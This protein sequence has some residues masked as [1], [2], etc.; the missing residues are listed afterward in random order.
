MDLEITTLDLISEENF[1]LAYAQ[2][3]GDGE[4]RWRA[5]NAINQPGSLYSESVSVKKGCFVK[6]KSDFEV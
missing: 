2:A 4:E 6:F 5:H 3:C 1:A